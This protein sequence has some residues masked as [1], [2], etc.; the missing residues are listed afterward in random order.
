MDG[1]P[2]LRG[3]APGA[4]IGWRDGRAI[5]WE[6]F[7]ASAAAL[8]SA[9]SGRRF[10]I[11]LCEDRIN[12]LLGFAAAL[13]ARATSLLPQSHAP[14]AI[15][16]L[17][18][19]YPDSV[20]IADGSC[21]GPT[22]PARIDITE[23]PVGPEIAA[24]P[25]IPLDHAAIVA[26]TS[27]S[28]GAPQPHVKS[29]RSLTRASAAVKARL[30]IAP[31]SVLLGAVPAQHMWGFETTVM[32]PLQTG[33]AVAGGCPLLPAEIAAALRG[34]PAPRWLVATPLHLR[35]CIAA[36]EALPPLAAIASATTP[37]TP[38]LATA[39]EQR[40]GAPLIEVYGSTETGTLATRRPTQSAMFETVGGIELAV[41]ADRA[42]ARGGH[43]AEPMVLNDVLE[44]QGSTRFI[45]H[46]RTQD[47]VK[48]A[49]KRG[50][51]V[52]LNAELARVPGVEDSAIWLREDE[53]AQAR[54]V[55]F[56]VAPTTSAP[57][58]MEHLRQ[59]LDPVFLPRPLILV[60]RLPRNRASK[61]TQDSLRE[62][63]AAHGLATSRAAGDAAPWQEVA[64][65]HP[66]LPFHFPGDPLVPGAWL[67]AL[68][69]SAARE[70]FG[71]HLSVRGVPDTRFRQVLRPAEPF[72][73]TLDRVAAGRIK[74]SVDT[75]NARVMDGALLVRDAARPA[76]ATERQV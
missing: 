17:G 62:L 23:W 35:A 41:R 36:G 70:R 39:V 74:F 42:V 63:A 26:F 3:Y 6:R 76:S 1:A 7:A 24:V 66:A 53:G 29:W 50:S 25:E 18:E 47:L 61:L 2:L 37:L 33:C 75:A 67:L 45:L 28:T 38:E 34:I 14:E 69:E 32:L 27:G 48:I 40:Y 65:E 52:A 54:V 64:A 60:D 57:A 22:A 12:F 51:L 55:A 46:G 44:L 16:T 71:A 5:A 73:I 56:A 19:T 20:L 9:L 72:R 59:R 4:P 13:I 21:Q 43:L 49:G 58:I 11:N 10:C 31:G 15:N 8:S 30:S 68:V